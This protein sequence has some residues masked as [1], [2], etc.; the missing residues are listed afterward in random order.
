MTNS[1]S[2]SRRTVVKG[3]AWAAPAVVVASSVP[4]LA[5]SEKPE[6]NATGPDLGFEMNPLDILDGGVRTAGVHKGTNG[7]AGSTFT[8]NFGT[9]TFKLDGT[10]FAGRGITGYRINWATGKPVVLRSIDVDS[11]EADG[12]LV[13]GPKDQ[14]GVDEWTGE[15]FDINPDISAPREKNVGWPFVMS[16]RSTLPY[17]GTCKTGSGPA[18]ALLISVPFQPIFLKGLS[19]DDVQAEVTCDEVYYMNYVYL[20]GQLG[21]TLL[22]GNPQKAKVT[23]G[24]PQVVER[25]IP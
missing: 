25:P 7:K 2:P 10:P 13:S 3:A 24:V 5:V 21:C 18:R 20:A 1:T 15:F 16:V 11:W 4:A 6:C 17:R 23:V 19:I 14:T 12:S 9:W 8:F 22:V